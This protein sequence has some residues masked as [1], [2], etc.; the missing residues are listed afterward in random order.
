MNILI[1][2]AS[3]AV[4]AILLVVYIVKKDRFPEPTGMVL[5]TFFLGILICN[6]VILA[7]Y[8]V[9]DGFSGVSDPYIQA[10][11]QAFLVAG[12]CEEAFK[13]LVLHRFCA[14]KEDFDEPMDAMVYGVLASL[15]FAT[16]ENVLYVLEGGLEVA[17]LRA[18]TAVPAHACFGGLMGYFYARGHFGSGG[19]KAYV[20]ALVIPILVHGL[21]DLP[22]F[23]I[24]VPDVEADGVLSFL[25]FAG[26]AVLVLTLI[27]VVRRLLLRMRQEQDQISQPPLDS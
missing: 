1:A 21:Y 8:F 15:G 14:R 24:G 25:L 19:R 7:E 22:L 6:P 3:A 13:F 17:M 11:I 12:L 27:L 20:A 2:V 4:P 18:V 9:A 10:F 16:L 23:L 26:F 5:K